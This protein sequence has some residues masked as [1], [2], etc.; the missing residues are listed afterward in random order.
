[1][2][3]KLKTP[4]GGSVTLTV[5]DTVEHT[6]KV[7]AGKE[8]LAGSTGSSL[9]GYMPAG[10]GAVARTVQDK[11]RESVSVLDFG[12][13]ADFGVTSAATNN[14]AINIALASFPAGG[15]TL[16]IPKGV[17]WGPYA[18]VTIPN[19]V[20][21]DDL[22][23]W[24]Y[25]YSQWTGQIKYMMKTAAPGTKNAN[26]FQLIAPYHPAL[27]IDNVGDG[28]VEQRGSVVFR[29]NGATDW[30]FG[31]GA[32][33]DRILR[34]AYYG[35]YAG[36]AS[37]GGTTVFGLDPA[38]GS[39]G[40]NGIAASGVQYEFYGSING[41]YIARYTAVG[42]NNVVFQF[43]NAA[44]GT[45][46]SLISKDNGSLIWN[47][48]G[49]DRITFSSKGAISGNQILV[50]PKTGSYGIVGDGNTPDS[51][52]TFTNTGTSGGFIFNLPNAV[53]G[54]FYDF[55]V[56]VAQ[57]MRLTPQTAD[58]FR[59]YT[60]GGAIS[61]KTA[62]KYMQSTTLGSVCHLRCVIAGTWEYERRG[63]W[64]DE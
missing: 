16:L 33:N 63:T 3:L 21:I 1:M 51:G 42:T 37:P 56:T 13:V 46:S 39:F 32:Y 10:T 29:R 40:F 50:A 9:V 23:G 24:D 34:I 55:Y 60:D 8:E 7:V 38:T 20:E 17:K 53:A 11:M 54:L 52:I 6:T 43:R 18:S 30:Q 44:N 27:I 58:K 31:P 57:N 22:S 14:A 59:G 28:S 36:G 15:G 48:L 25:V 47:Q 19:E 5:A 61:T 49:E 2:S 62:N 4:S 64:A 35:T 12:A 45:R 26:E 41:T